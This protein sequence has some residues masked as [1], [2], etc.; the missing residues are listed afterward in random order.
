MSRLNK[1]SHSALVQVAA[2]VFVTGATGLYFAQKYMQHKVR[3]LPHY[4]EGL[5]II[6]EHQKAKDALGPPIQVG[7]VDLSDRRR[8]YVDKTTSML[9]IPVTGQ[10]DAG[11]AEIYAT[12][13]APEKAFVTSKV[14]LTLNNGAVVIFDDGRWPFN[15]KN[16]ETD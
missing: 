12:R 6:S 4:L 13:E 9:R 3:K 10:L 2:G 5:T 14:R 11:F 7:A 8:N 15:D 16:L 1:I